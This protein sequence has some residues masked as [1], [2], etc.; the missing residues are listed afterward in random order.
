MFG[1]SILL[2]EERKRHKNNMGVYDDIYKK[3]T[4]EEKGRNPK[5][6]NI[7]DI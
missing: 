5:W 1:I 6:V 2:E 7:G 4:R 3:T